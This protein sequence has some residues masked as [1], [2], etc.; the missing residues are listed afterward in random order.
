MIN[1]KEL[2]SIIEAL[3]QIKS[4]ECNP[5]PQYSDAVYKALGILKP[6][7]NYP[8]HYAKLEGKPIGEMNRREIATMLT[9]INR[10]ERFCDGHIASFVES[11]ELL[12]L[13][14]RLRELESR[15][16][17]GIF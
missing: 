2:D 16:I 6:D 15:G 1:R 9:F 5:Y 8:E 17:Q 4:V 10:G 7:Y 12:Q 3:Q 14:L 13:M 11:G